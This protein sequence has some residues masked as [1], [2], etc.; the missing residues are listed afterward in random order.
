MIGRTITGLIGGILLSIIALKPAVAADPKTR[1]LNSLG[2]V[3]IALTQVGD[4]ARPSVVFVHGLM[5]ASAVWKK[6]LTSSLAE[7]YYLSAVD[8]RGHGSSG[9]PVEPFHYTDTRYIAADIA[10]A[11][12]SLEGAKPIVVAHSYGGLFVMDYVRHYGAKN[13]SGIIL[14]G[15]S[16]GISVPKPKV[17]DTPEKLARIERSRSPNIFINTQWTTSF[18]DDYLLG[19]QN[20]D[21]RDAELLRVAAMM[22]PH[23]VRRY[24]REHNNNNFDIAPKVTL[25]VVLIAGE[26][27]KGANQKVLKFVKD[28]LPNATIRTLK[29][30]AHM[31]HWRAPDQ[32]NAALREAL[33]SLK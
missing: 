24:M 26:N 1:V 10:T 13:L 3:P 22:V 27:H 12:D 2:D 6:Q 32:F 15:A 33:E 19:G 5:S 17:P 25:P 28:T 21:T 18:V 29:D 4:P 7:D 9:K 14:V 31:A 23:Y 30:Q 8:V 11:I 20:V 16:G